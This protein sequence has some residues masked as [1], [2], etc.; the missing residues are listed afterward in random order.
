MKGMR[1][2]RKVAHNQRWLEGK[3][4]ELGYIFYKGIVIRGKKQKNTY[5]ITQTKLIPVLQLHQMSDEAWNEL[6]KRM[7]R[8]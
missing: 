2:Y 8:R 3:W 1:K 4:H 5:T 7:N 6:A